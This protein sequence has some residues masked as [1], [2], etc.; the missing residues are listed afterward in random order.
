MG[1]RVDFDKM[2]DILAAWSEEYHILHRPGIR[3]KRKFVTGKSR[4]LVRSCWIVS[5]IFP[6]RKRIIQCHRRCFILPI[7]M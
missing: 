2:N 4:R 6:R 7:L 3:E 5:P 1:Y